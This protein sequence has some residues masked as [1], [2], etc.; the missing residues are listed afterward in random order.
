M[1]RFLSVDSL[2]NE[3]KYEWLQFPQKLNVYTYVSN[4]P[5]IFI[6]SDGNEGINC[7]LKEF[8]F[9]LGVGTKFKVFG[10]GFSLKAEYK[11]GVVSAT[12]LNEDSTPTKQA[13][14]SI[15]GEVNLFEKIKLKGKGEA[16][17]VSGKTNV[18]V[19]LSGKSNGNKVGVNR[20]KN[21]KVSVELLDIGESF[22]PLSV[23]IKLD[24]SENEKG[25]RDVTI[26][27]TLL[28]FQPKVTCTIGED[29]KQLQNSEIQLSS[30]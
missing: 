13:K 5:S 8:N 9:V 28:I 14:L 3:S 10:Q 24:S 7:Q 16:D 29:T 6:D 15:A 26:T 30:P 22:G 2:A 23:G 20:D 12:S 21:E 11:K 19:H 27:P 25:Q 1:G 4:N 17:F 18:S